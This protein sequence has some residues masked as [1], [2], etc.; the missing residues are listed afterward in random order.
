MDGWMIRLR[1]G[2]NIGLVAL[3]C[4]ILCWGWKVVVINT[5]RPSA[6]GLLVC[7]CMCMC[8]VSA[9]T[10][11]FIK[12][13]QHL[14]LTRRHAFTDTH[15]GQRPTQTLIFT[16]PLLCS[17]TWTSCT[18]K[19]TCIHKFVP[20]HSHPNKDVKYH[21][22]VSL[23]V[24]IGIITLKGRRDGLL[25]LSRCMIAGTSFTVTELQR[26]GFTILWQNVDHGLRSTTDSF[27]FCH[28][29]LSSDR[30]TTIH[31]ESGVILRSPLIT[32]AVHAC[33]NQSVCSSPG[34]FCCLSHMIVEKDLLY[35][36]QVLE[37]EC[38]QQYFHWN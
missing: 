24:L 30:H 17:A 19:W 5:C 15:I 16:F 27:Y 9:Y 26:Q 28:Q 37:F 13:S 18:H 38:S 6:K 12:H 20:I 14:F 21:W 31:A 11:D 35:N 10:Q 29:S 4:L 32:A 33:Q 1:D 36:L 34:E 3:L 8:A 7:V 2:L 22:N 23:V 25:M